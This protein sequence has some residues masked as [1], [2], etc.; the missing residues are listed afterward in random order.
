[1]DALAQLTWNIRP[2]ISGDFFILGG[3][4]RVRDENGADGDGSEGLDD[5]EQDADSE[6]E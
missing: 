3:V 5:D 2:L 4:V 6:G 1:M